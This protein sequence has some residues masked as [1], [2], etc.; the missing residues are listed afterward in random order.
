MN[1]SSYYFFFIS[2]IVAMGI[3]TLVGYFGFQYVYQFTSKEVID[4]RI[5]ANRQEA[6]QIARLLSQKIKD[7]YTKQQVIEELQKSIQ[8]TPID[9]GFVC[10]FTHSGKQIC[11][12]LPSKIGRI[13]DSTNSVVSLMNNSQYKENFEN[14]LLS[15]KGQGG[16]RTFFN[17]KY[18]EIIYVAPVEGTDFMLAVHANLAHINNQLKE[19]R[20][21]LLL[22][23]V[24]F[25]LITTLLIFV[26][27][28]YL[29]LSMENRLK[30]AVHQ[31]DPRKTEIPVSDTVNMAEQPVANRE[32]SPQSRILANQGNKLVPVLL[33]DI[34]FVYIEY[35]LTYLVKHNGG[36]FT[37]NLSL[38]ELMEQ[39]DPHKFF[40]ANRQFIL[41]INSI[42]KVE[43]YG[44]N[45]LRVK[46]TPPSSKEVII[47]KTKMAAFKKWLG[48]N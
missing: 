4:T 35:K 9:K 1:K 18:T 22:I 5:E 47:S 20:Q 19:F 37:S 23:F 16:I 31:Q 3:T 34:A 40:R 2:L 14:I 29:Y 15:G 42:S 32:N 10:M 38:E 6:V 25:G 43:K 13:I 46:L 36:K 26:F 30:K 45:Q 7:G 48:E 28:R 41:S 8:Y 11:H 17:R 44:N 12:P 21:K 27:F 39:M 33:D 24:I